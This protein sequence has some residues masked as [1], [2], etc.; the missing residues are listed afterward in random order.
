MGSRRLSS[1]IASRTVESSWFDTR[2]LWDGWVI[3]RGDDRGRL[4][5]TA[6][7]CVAVLS[8]PSATLS[9]YVSGGGA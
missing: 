3:V 5:R 4:G 8:A 9:A 1:R 6:D 2:T 7:A